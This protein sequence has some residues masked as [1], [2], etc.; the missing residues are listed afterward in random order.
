MQ[1]NCRLKDE[2]KIGRLSMSKFEQKRKEEGRQYLELPLV[3][4]S[5]GGEGG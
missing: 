4:T 3:V 5:F 2:I 1:E